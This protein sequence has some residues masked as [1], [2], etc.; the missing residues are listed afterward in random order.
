LIVGIGWGTK[1]IL[2]PVATNSLI[3]Q[4][5]LI[6]AVDQSSTIEKIAREV[7]VRIVTESAPG[8]GVTIDLIARSARFL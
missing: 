1:G 8:S 2:I 4:S 3:N 6:V 7:T 5:S